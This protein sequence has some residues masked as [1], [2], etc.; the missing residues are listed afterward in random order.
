MNAFHIPLAPKRAPQQVFYPRTRTLKQEGERFLCPLCDE[1][2]AWTQK[3]IL[4]DQLIP[5]TRYILRSG[6]WIFPKKGVC[7]LKNSR[8][9]RAERRQRE[10]ENRTEGLSE[11]EV[12]ADSQAHKRLDKQARDQ[13]EKAGQIQPIEEPGVFCCSN[14]KALV[15]IEGSK[16]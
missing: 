6:V 12:R 8:E 16:E 7:Q 1:E 13:D 11:D 14:C 10:R 5:V 4:S 15:K 3:S 2:L 9:R